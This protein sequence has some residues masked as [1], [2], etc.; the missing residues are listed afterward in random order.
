MIGRAGKR[1][2]PADFGRISPRRSA[3]EFSSSLLRPL[4]WVTSQALALHLDC[5]TCLSWLCAY[6]LP[7]EMD[8]AKG[9]LMVHEAGDKGKG[10]GRVEEAGRQTRPREPGAR[11]VSAPGL[12]S[13]PAW[14]WRQQERHRAAPGR[15]SVWFASGDE[16]FPW[17]TLILLCLDS[18]EKSG[19]QRESQPVFIRRPQGQ[20]QQG[21]CVQLFAPLDARV[22]CFSSLGAAREVRSLA[23]CYSNA[24][25]LDCREAAYVPFLL[26]G[27]QRSQSARRRASAASIKP[28]FETPTGP[29]RGGTR[30]R[31]WHVQDLARELEQPARLG[32]AK[33]RGCML[34]FKDL[35]CRMTCSPEQSRFLAVNATAGTPNPHVVAMVYALRPEYTQAVYDSCKDVR[36]VVLGIK[37][38][39]LMCGGRVLGCTPQKWLDFLGSTPADGGYSPFKIHHVITQEPLV[40]SRGQTLMPLSVPFLQSC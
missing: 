9:W 40:L 34:N 2:R 36:S 28:P 5:P 4:P 18:G 38:M 33:C 12:S 6:G 39:T 25:A 8:D 19:R 15:L 30:P 20:Q 11:L 32:M 29:V 22:H 7:Q 13:N 3:G 1:S 21:K 16:T 23:R 24:L 31:R 17:H 14:R 27:P 26:L 37:L 35:L 10:G